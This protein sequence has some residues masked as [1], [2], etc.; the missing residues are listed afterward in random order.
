MTRSTEKGYD[1]T[2]RALKEFRE[3][4]RIKDI[5][6]KFIND[7]E[8]FLVKRGREHGLGDVL[9]TRANRLK[10]VRTIVLDIER[11]GIPIK[12]R[13]GPVNA[14]FPKLPKTIRSSNMTN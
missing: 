9:G 4:I 12:I 10:H 7:F 5:D 14:R 1:T 3:K 13:T 2:R 6:A 8:R 11:R